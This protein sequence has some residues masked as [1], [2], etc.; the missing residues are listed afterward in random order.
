M[1][2]RLK[3]KDVDGVSVGI[4]GTITWTVLAVAATLGSDL[5]REWDVLWWR[6]VTYSGVAVGILGSIHVIRRRRRLHG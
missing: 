2:K 3:A 5:L 6:D 1:A 4:I